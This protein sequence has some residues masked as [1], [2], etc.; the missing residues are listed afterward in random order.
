MGLS[1]LIS[2]SN[3]DAKGAAIH[4]EQVGKIRRMRRWNKISA[5]GNKS[6]ARNLNNAFT[7]MSRIKDKLSLPDSILV[8]AAYFYRKALDKNLIKG[9]SIDGMVIASIYAACREIAIPRKLVE[10]ATA[11]NS[12]EVFAGRCYRLLLKH[13]KIQN[14]PLATS[15]SYLSKA[16]NNVNVS[17]RTYRKALEMLAKLKG[18]HMSVGKNPNAVAVAVLYAACLKEGERINQS[19]IA[20]AGNMSVVTLRKRFSDVKK[21]LA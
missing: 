10:L 8:K 13:L 20:L 3:V 2:Y 17:E 12:D 5:Y 14:M 9:R 11:A 1:T 21:I 18:N 15:S 6:Y 19:Q 16:A 7:I 4:P